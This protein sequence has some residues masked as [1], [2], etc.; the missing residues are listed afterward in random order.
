MR[1]FVFALSGL[2]FSV[3]GAWLFGMDVAA[4]Q[5]LFTGERLASG[6]TLLSEEAERVAA[7]RSN[8]DLPCR[9]DVQEAALT[10]SLALL[11]HRRK[12]AA[13][14]GK[15]DAAYAQ[16]Q[17]GVARTLS[18]FPLSGNAWMRSA[19]ASMLMEGPVDR[20]FSQAE[21]SQLTMPREAWILSVRIPFL[22]ALAQTARPEAR[23]LL[24]RDLDTLLRYA[25]LGQVQSVYE[26]LGVHGRK[27]MRERLEA[28]NREIIA[29]LDRHRLV[30]LDQMLEIALMSDR[31]ARYF[32]R[33]G[34]CVGER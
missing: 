8:A 24:G 29:A 31:C 15:L 6:L 5:V 22:V 1:R 4:R 7:Y 18:C 25:P 10:V 27:L 21:M 23:D 13:A 34:A 19:M 28:D 16:V 3:A 17:Q 20:V 14:G 11:D 33:L 2:A 32:R 26:T 30:R 12:D 9:R